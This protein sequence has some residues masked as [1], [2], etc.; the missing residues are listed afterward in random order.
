M[1]GLRRGRSYQ[2]FSVA[3]GRRCNLQCVRAWLLEDSRPRYLPEVVPGI[4]VAVK[5][6]GSSRKR[7]CKDESKVWMLGSSV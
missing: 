2:R 7:E 3:T 6:T 4:I 1:S 5:P